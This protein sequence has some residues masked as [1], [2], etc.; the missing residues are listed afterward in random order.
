[1]TPRST[2]YRPGLNPVR[3]LFLAA[4][5]IVL[6]SLAKAG[7]RD[8]DKTV[9]CFVSHKTSH[10]FGAH[11]YAA[12]C[13][14][15]GQWLEESYPDAKIES[16]YSINWPENPE[17]FFK[18]ADSVIFF[19]SGGG[20]H[21][22]NGH[23]P[24]FDK[25]MRTGAGLAC[26]HYA[27]EVPI[28]PS[29]KG[30]LAWMGGYF[31]T[32]WSVN[33]TWKPKFEVFSD[34]PAANGLKPF[35][36]ND[37]WYFHMRF[38]GD[39]KGVTPILS[40]VAPDETMSR[41]DGAHS[42]NP[43]VRKA[44]AN[45]EPQHVAWAYQR[46]SDYA[47]GC[48]FGFTGLHFHWNWE[49]DNF[50]KTVL[51]GVAWSAGLEIPKNGIETKTPTR[52]FLEKNA[53]EY[54]GEQNRKKEAAKQTSAPKTGTPGAKPIYESPVIAHSNPPSHSVDIDVELPADSKE[55]VLVIA[56]A[57]DGISNDWAGW[58]EPRLV[59][60][61]GSEKSLTSLNWKI[62][63]SGY[64]GVNKNAN[65]Q[66]RPMLVKGKLVEDGIGAHANSVIVYDL[67]KGAKRFKARGVLD[68][69][70]T[71]RAGME[72][73]PTS[74]RFVVFNEAGGTQAADTYV[75]KSSDPGRDASEAVESLEIHPDLAVQL[76]ASEPMIT[77][78][79]CIDI[80]AKGRVWVC[81]VV[82]YR[83]NSGKRPEGDQ[84]LILE[85]TD[86]DAKADKKTVFYQG[87]DVD[88]AHG[89]CVLGD[90]VIISCGDEVFSLYDRDGDGKADPDSKEVMFTKIGG[91]QHDHGIHA[92][93]FGPDG[94][95]YFNFGNAGQQLCDPEGNLI[96]D[97]HGIKCTNQGN[98][99]YQEGM[100][101]RC[102][103]DGTGVELLAWNFRNN[104]EVCVDSFGTMWQS[105][106][107]DD[108]NKGV[109]INYV[110]EFGNYGYKD[111]ITGAGWRDPRIG[112][113]EEIPER[114]WHQNDP[115]VVP[116]LLVTGAG[117]PTGICVYEGDLLPEI[118]HGQM[119]HCDAGPNVVRSYITKPDGAGYKVTETVDLMRSTKD[120]WFR[121]SDV[122]VAPDGSLFVADWYDPGVGGHGMGDIEKGRIFRVI[123]K[124]NVGARAY[125][126]DYS[127]S[128]NGDR[129][130]GAVKQLANPNA[131]VQF[132]AWHSLS[133]A[134]DEAEWA[135]SK[136]AALNIKSGSRHRARAIWL[137]GQMENLPS[138]IIKQ[139]LRD[140]D[141]DIRITMVRALR[142]RFRSKPDELL[143]FITA[144]VAE[145]DPGLCREM[146]LAL[147]FM[148]GDNA[149]ELWRFLA[150]QYDPG[151]AWMLEALGIG[152]EGRW[153]RRLRGLL[154]TLEFDVV[155]R[156][157]PEYVR[158]RRMTDE[159]INRNRSGEFFD[160]YVVAGGIELKN[161]SE[162]FLRM[163]HFLDDPDAQARGYRRLFMQGS[164]KASLFA[165]SKIGP[166]EI[167]QIEGG[168]ARL[169]AL[170]APV[171]GTAEFVNL[172]E[173]LNLSG[174]PDE[175]AAF[176][177]GHPD[178]PESVKAARLLLQTNRGKVTEYLRDSK[179]LGRASAMARALGKT[180]DRSVG[181]ILAAELKRPETLAPLAIELVNA[182]A[183]NG[184][185]GRDLLKLAQ[186]GKL[187]DS[188][189]PVAALAIARSPDAG[190][191]N[192]ARDI[193]PVP[194]AAGAE[195]FPPLPE[196]VAQNG[197][198]SKG[199][200]LFV[201]ATCT[202]CHLVKGEG[203]AFG[204][205]L[206]EIGNKLSR[207]GMFEAILYPSAAISHGFH[208]VSVTKKDGS[209]LV[210]YVT[211]E[212]DE[213]VQLRLPGGVDLS[214]DKDGIDKREELSLSLMPP[215][216]A[217]VIGADGLVDLVTWLQ[218]LK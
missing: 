170:L 80:D 134:G 209:A 21:L 6:P 34:H 127:H 199:H 189:K 208:G 41:A 104:W 68:D 167:Q 46:G 163:L 120:R 146:A 17:A 168:P 122:C 78:P 83:R 180:G 157:D 151:D 137:L 48:G 71:V 166:K 143:K 61:D 95:L 1:M 105:D 202:T 106:N 98:R 63:S 171:R 13:R 39:M 59:M 25:V 11:E 177:A 165:A 125:L 66:G 119:I 132:A 74:V 212:T 140:S 93:H 129:F 79:S 190:L 87:H 62:A 37:E 182:M 86:G 201:K 90:R 15:I 149:D 184:R 38:M 75:K 178:A 69:G 196:L 200:D 67:P 121:P 188:L 30:M 97:I 114:H 16:R 103:L 176:I 187:D 99:P 139:L 33:P 8:D 216:L 186:E 117:S 92:V 60:A 100:I 77:S 23:V 217:A 181:D 96:T 85:D 31:E 14:L 112:M 206:S 7:P 135:L 183:M 88:S 210:G 218:T 10:G 136:E 173:R 47:N 115:G 40:A 19:C 9:L 65:C 152:A 156:N 70:G 101:F 197:D 109:R 211:G 49:D 58:A 185:S 214:V 111:E 207:E 91:K 108:G 53:L 36:I 89:I 51:N 4:L 42:G 161:P 81:D 54:G 179:N 133:K 55:L 20:G 205:D 2:L 192:D 84:I 154:A 94:R 52:E 145:N 162:K 27:V 169:D 57:G 82:N 150:R 123:P 24:E 172:A 144:E 194:K 76:F 12:G 32:D 215:G 142:K 195:N 138:K 45:H 203:V 193:L 116:N 107:D 113:S 110:M 141:S 160:A 26:L 158:F 72:K 131:D 175:L 28:G 18:D 198:A 128:E 153:L 191:R 64:A 130:S 3:W 148:D 126:A 44:V 50:R 124:S 102:E 43:A 164:P 155:P 5:A 29:A 147:R 118:F 204:P 73:T 159:L 22:V 56:D 35:E 213:E 174:F